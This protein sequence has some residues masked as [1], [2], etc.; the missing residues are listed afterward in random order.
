MRDGS[1]WKD[2]CLD[3]RCESGKVVCAKEP[4][5]DCKSDPNP[6]CCPHCFE[7]KVEMSCLDQGGDRHLSGQSWTTQCKQCQCNV[8]HFFHRNCDKNQ[9]INLIFLQMGE[10]HCTPLECPPVHCA[11]PI[12]PP[13]QCCPVCLWHEAY[14]VNNTTCSHSGMTFSSGQVWRINSPKDN[15]LTC[16]K[17]QCKVQLLKVILVTFQIIAKQMRQFSRIR[18]AIPIPDT[19]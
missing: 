1:T 8:S 10:A 18:N 4:V 14:N 17:C 15:S 12:V 5:C 6:E 16:T 13:G 19:R 2:G 9:Y 11:H 3:C 7:S